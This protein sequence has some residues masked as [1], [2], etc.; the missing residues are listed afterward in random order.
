MESNKLKEIDIKNCTFYC[1][2]D[3]VKSKDFDF[4]NILVDRKSNRNILV[5]DVSY[6]TLFGPKPLRFRMDLLGFIM[7][8]LVLFHNEKCDAIVNVI[9][10]LISQK[11]E[12]TCFFS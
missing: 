12:T 4:D 9:R 1:F 2:D 7:A 8:Y 3:I 11:S 5:Y 6:K 10:Y